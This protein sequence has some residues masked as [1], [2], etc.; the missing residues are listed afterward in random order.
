MWAAARGGSACW[1]GRGGADGVGGACLGVGCGWGVAQG[2][3]IASGGL[4][5]ISS[6]GILGESASHTRPFTPSAIHIRHLQ[7]AIHTSPFTRC[8]GFAV[9]AGTT[10]LFM[11]HPS[12]FFGL[13]RNP[14]ASSHPSTRLVQP[15]G[16]QMQRHPEIAR[17]SFPPSPVPLHC[18][19]AKPHTHTHNTHTP[20]PVRHELSAHSCPSPIST[21][22]TYL[23]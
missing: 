20:A 23:H 19:S 16:F 21:P 13:S 4:L 7:P 6:V 15:C 22:H 17:P 12:L 3:Y 14:T 2:R 11:A 18:T 9:G 10:G 1:G 5:R 8:A